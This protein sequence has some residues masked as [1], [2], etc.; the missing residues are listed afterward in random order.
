M[1]NM[2]SGDSRLEGYI[3]VDRYNLNADAPWDAGNLPLNDCSVALIA[4]YQTIEHF[5]RHEILPIFREWYRVCK[6]QGEVHITT[7]D[8]VGSC[9]L[10]VND[11]N[12]QWLL[13]RIFGN[14]SHGGQFHKWGFTVAELSNMLG[15][16]G[17]ASVVV[18]NYENDDKSL[19]LYAKAIR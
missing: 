1:L 16:V 6:P 12:R 3:N 15:M 10:V 18:A 4:C 8:I 14:Q 11:P 13:A 7:P 19:F 2:G 9:Q 17:F 5:G